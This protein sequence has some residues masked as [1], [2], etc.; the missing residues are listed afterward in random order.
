MYICGSAQQLPGSEKRKG[1]ATALVESC[2]LQGHRHALKP[3]LRAR[4]YHAAA[5]NFVS[6]L[7]ALRR[8]WRNNRLRDYS[9]R[10]GLRD[11]LRSLVDDH[12]SLHSA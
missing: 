4:E 2:Q 9:T 11:G 7:L 1:A 8:L 3:P 10:Y 12:G 6:P 5:P